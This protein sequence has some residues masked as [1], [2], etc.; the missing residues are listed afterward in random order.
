ML[1]SVTVRVPATSANM[2]PGFDTLGVALSLYNT[3]TFTRSDTPSVTGCDTRFAGGDNLALR[4]FR[5]TCTHVGVIPP[6]V[7]L[8]I[9]ADVP[10]SRGL[11][12]SATMIVGGILGADRLLQLG[13]TD[14]E[15]FRLATAM[16]G[17]PDNVAPALYGG[18]T[19]SLLDGEEPYTARIP[20]HPA[21]RFC[22]FIPD[23]ETGTRQA[24]AV[25]P[26]SV[27]RADAVY[28]VA[29]VATL[30]PA[31]AA[32]ND[33]LLSLSLSDR[34]HESYRRTL[35][36]GFDRVKREAFAAGAVA[37][38]LSGSGSTLMAIYRDP[39]F[40][41]AMEQALAPME[42]HWRVLPLTAETTGATVLA[43]R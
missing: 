16:E 15:H 1:T 41:H 3:L 30:L 19:A 9:R 22:A 32:G 31:L 33:R 39:A 18:C 26:D 43:A 42:H 10:A 27:P 28:N 34:L 24:R 6:A 12:S 21:Y 2:G 23:F 17:H 13:L 20:V 38:F 25:L 40:P 4:A 36:P 35:I 14:R 11:G 29:H 5:A 8:H 7:A 37:F